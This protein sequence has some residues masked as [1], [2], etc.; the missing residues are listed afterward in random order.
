M[1]IIDLTTDATIDDFGIQ[2]QSKKYTNHLQHSE[3]GT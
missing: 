3:K 1:V 2:Q